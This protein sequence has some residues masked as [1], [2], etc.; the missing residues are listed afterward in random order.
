MLRP[1]AEMMRTL[2]LLRKRTDG[3]ASG[4]VVSSVPDVRTIE[5]DWERA[6]V[7]SVDE[8]KRRLDFHAL[9]HTF[10]T[11]LDRHGCSRATKKRLMR[12]ASDDV[13]DGYAHAELREMLLALVKIPSPNAVTAVAGATGMDGKAVSESCPSVDH[14]WDQTRVRTGQ[15]VS[16]MEGQHPTQNDI[17]KKNLDR[18]SSLPVSELRPPITIGTIQVTGRQQLQAEYPSGLRGRIAN[19]LFVGSNPTSASFPLLFIAI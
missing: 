8:K 19:P 15:S 2:K 14:R 9:R 3:T 6:G 4:P 5:K 12:H 10:Q 7:A 13:T 17:D 18:Y 16:V 11:S 1:V